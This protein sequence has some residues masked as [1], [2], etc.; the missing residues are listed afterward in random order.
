M[1]GAPVWLAGLLA[2]GVADSLTEMGFNYADI[3]T[4]PDVRKK[5]EKA[6]GGEELN[7]ASHE[8]IRVK[9]QELLMDQADTSAAKVGIANFMNPLNF[10]PVAGKFARL[11]KVGSGRV[12]TM[13]RQAL[14]TGM[15]ESIEE[16]WQ[17]MGSQYTAAEAKM[18][19][20][21]EAGVKEI[22]ELEASWTRAGYEALMGLAVGVPIGL[23]G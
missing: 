19:G 18:A 13:G 23:G 20:M 9:V 1:A 2:Y 7:E 21:E 11:M 5:M 8:E 12:G 14:G 3:V 15:R 22:P 10:H 17:S 4:D 16:F 6:L